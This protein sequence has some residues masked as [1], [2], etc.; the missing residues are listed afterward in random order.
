MSIQTLKRAF[1]L[2]SALLAAQTLFAA[3]PSAR[4]GARA[5]YNDATN[6]GILFGGLTATD[7]GSA[8]AY[9]L[10]ETWEW[11]GTRW[12][13]RYPAHAP[14]ARFSH[15]MTYDSIRER[16]VLFGGSDT[17]AEFNDTWVY[18]NRDWKQIETPNAPAKRMMSGLAFDPVRDRVV[19]FGGLSI[20]DDRTTTERLYDMWEF[21]GTTWTRVIESGPQVRS[22]LL[23]WNEKAGRVQLLGNVED[24]VTRLYEYD[25][26]THA[27]NNIE[28]DAANAPCVNE[29]G[30]AFD[31]E[32]G[33]VIVASGVCIPTDTTKSSSTLESVHLW[34]G[35]TWTKMEIANAAFRATNSAI[36]FD[37]ANKQLV[38]F[39]G[40]TA[41]STLPRSTTMTL[42]E[43]NWGFPYDRSSP[44]GRSLFGM[45]SDP[46]NN[47]IWMVGGLTEGD[48]VSEV[49]KFKDGFWEQITVEGGPDCGVSNAAFD[50][51]RA[52][53][54]VLCAD[55]TVFE[56]DNTA[57]K[58]FPASDMKTRPIGRNFA[59]F[60][61]DQNIR[62]S[63]LFGGLDMSTGDYQNKTWTWDGTTWAEV[64]PSSKKRAHARALTSMW[65]DPVL[66]R[67]VVFGGVG[68]KEREG[69]LERFNDMWSFDGKEWTELKPAAKPSTRYGAQVTADPRTNRTILHGGL[70]LETD[71][72]GLQK[73]VY[74]NETWEWDGTTWRQLATEGPAPAR[75]N[76]G[77]AWDPSGTGYILFGGWSGYYHSDTWRLDNNRWTVFAE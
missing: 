42:R 49:W 35:E 23:F 65:Y 14:A 36:F 43:G 72:K 21:D 10:D 47:A 41:Y 31:P 48:Y 37:K 63:V 27:W 3:E 55:S 62:K 39:G 54:V 17:L 38:T 1:V 2:T 30:A 5:T 45:A 20:G 15:S 73:Q 9:V 12:I 6:T 32:N 7:A 29:S 24:F 56:F 53:L 28:F 22:P 66:R 60:V 34:D 16:I 18:E 74:T 19:L 64:K 26:T 77:I 59:S 44:G 58:E 61:Y 13:H 71:D 68:R 4:A 51:N 33:R 52:K 67:T 75:E 57:W 69:R 8:R 11:E 25:T 70:K 76:S 40:F 50:I 46:V